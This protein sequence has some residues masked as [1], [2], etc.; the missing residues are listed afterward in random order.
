[1]RTLLQQVGQEPETK[2]PRDEEM[3]EKLKS[4]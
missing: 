2:N 1:M 3:I 4:Q